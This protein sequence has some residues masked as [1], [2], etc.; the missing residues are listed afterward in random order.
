[1]KWLFEQI[2]NIAPTIEE[3]VILLMIVVGAFGI[4]ASIVTII[5]AALLLAQ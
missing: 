2:L 5:F 3:K 1:M 4:L